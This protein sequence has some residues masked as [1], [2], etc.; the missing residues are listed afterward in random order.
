MDI[1]EVHSPKRWI[2]A[3]MFIAGGVIA[4]FSIVSP[5]LAAAHHEDDVSLWPKAVMLAPAL[6]IIG[7]IL[8]VFGNHK[9]GQIMGS[10]QEPSVLGIAIC[11]VIAAICILLNEWLKSRLR[12]YGYDV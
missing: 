8:L 2:G 4:Y 11:I 7:L 6:I 5:L 1:Q 12:G 3:L 9:A 10:R